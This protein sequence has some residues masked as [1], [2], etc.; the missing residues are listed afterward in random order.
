MRRYELKDADWARLAPL[1]PGKAGDAGR[2]A[3]DNRLFLNAVL[4]IAR[5]GAPWRD[6]PERFG[7]WNSTYRRF[8]RWAQKGVWQRVF[9]AVQDPDLDWAMLD[10]TSVRAHQHAAGQKSSALAEALGRSRGGF[11]SKLH[12]VVDAL[13]NPL[14]L[15]L[16]PG[17][18]ADCTVAADLLAGLAVGAVLADKAYDTD[19][20]VAGCA[21]T[22]AAL[23]VP[24]KRSRRVARV[25]DRNLYADRNKVERFFNRLKQYRRLA[26][27]YEK[28]GASFLA[29]AHC[30]ATLV[31]LL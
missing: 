11:T 22:G 4:W 31:W 27:R 18:Q 30:A 24:S 1:L 14:R 29:F 13:G 7:P 9:E 5:S 20:L 15:R 19:A 17:Q 2:S 25:L 6:L 28:T 21:Q 8:R 16:T 26:T 12:V 3:A 10:S 23:V